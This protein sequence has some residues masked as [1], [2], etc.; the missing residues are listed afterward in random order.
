MAAAQKEIN[1]M[2]R[3]AREKY[4]VA[5]EQSFSTID[6]NNKITNMNFGNKQIFT[7]NDLD[8][9]NGE[10]TPFFLLSLTAG[11][12]TLYRYS[13]FSKNCATRNPWA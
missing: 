9:A 6:N 10:R 2:L 4:W 11:K 13:Q 5:T 1:M 8:R 3:K 12:L 7:V